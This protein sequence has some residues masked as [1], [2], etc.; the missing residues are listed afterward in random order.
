MNALDA[1]GTALHALPPRGHAHGA[2]P[3]LAALR[4]AAPC[5]AGAGTTG[6]GCSTLPAGRRSR[7]CAVL[8]GALRRAGYWTGYVTDNPFLGFA[9]PYRRLRSSVDRFIRARRPGGRQR[10]GAS[11]QGARPLAASRRCARRQ[12][13]TTRVRK[14]LAS[15]DEYCA[16]RV[17]LVRRPRVHARRRGA[18][19]A[20]TPAARSR[21]WWT[22]SSRTSRGPR[23]ASTST[24]TATPTIAA[25]SR[26]CRA[27]GGSTTAFGPRA[28]PAARADARPL[29]GRGHDDRPLD[30]GAHRPPPRPPARPRDDRGAGERPRLL[31]RRARL[32]REDL[33]RAAPGARSHCRS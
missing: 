14:Y 21:W 7:A 24:S 22:P 12:D 5:P 10:H 9:P 30:G 19:R 33:E 17:A 23:R 28:G 27:T 20:A 16:R 6:P 25:P 13:P 15:A 8:P 1:P 4:A 31:P 11:G 18:E 29:R 2:V 32:D 3:Q 26:A